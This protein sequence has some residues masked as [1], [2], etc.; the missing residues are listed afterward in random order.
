MAPARTAPVYCAA[1]EP[2]HAAIHRGIIRAAGALFLF[3]GLVV[4]GW[5]VVF[6]TE[7]LY[8]GRIFGYDVPLDLHW[9]VGVAVGA[10]CI[11]TGL[12]LV[13]L[14]SAGWWFLLAVG[15]ADIAQGVTGP[16]PWLALLTAAML[17]YLFHLR[18]LFDRGAA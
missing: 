6:P 3:L 9:F 13:S 17:A 18:A 5:S 1:V 14:S 2:S 7:D 11:L 10:G 12:A 16:H 4:I 15:L 8:L